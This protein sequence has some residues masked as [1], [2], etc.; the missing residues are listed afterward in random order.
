MLILYLIAILSLE[1]DIIF[2]FYEYYAFALCLI[3]IIA[4]SYYIL[5]FK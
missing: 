3:K 4:K 5:P 2:Q 1:K